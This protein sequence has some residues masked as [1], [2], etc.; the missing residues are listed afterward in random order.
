MKICKTVFFLLIFSLSIP[1]FPGCKTSFAPMS[2]NDL[3]SNPD[4]QK[5]YSVL[6]APDPI[7]LPL[8]TPE[9]WA[10]QT[11]FDQD[12][13]TI[14]LQEVS[15]P[16][17]GKY[18]LLFLATGKYNHENQTARFTSPTIPYENADGSITYQSA[19]LVTEPSDLY[20]VYYS[21]RSSEF[22]GWGMEFEVTIMSY[23]VLSPEE[24]PDTISLS[25]Q[26]LN[27]IDFSFK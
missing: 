4:I 23:R 5:I 13:C 18:I 8:D 12:G 6:P 10:E 26:E 17:E 24:T 25:F 22:S 21:A 7:V 15:Q 27:Q 19:G 2:L 9:S 1:C 11:V 16:T 20:S 14:T 3:F